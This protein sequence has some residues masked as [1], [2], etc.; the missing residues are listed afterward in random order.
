MRRS[1][2]AEV[3]TEVK[4]DT[5]SEPDNLDI[6]SKGVS[7]DEN[8]TDGVND[9]N[10][11]VASPSSN[12]RTVTLSE[13]S[14]V[15]GQAN[16]EAEASW[17]QGV[18]ET[19]SVSPRSPESSDVS[20]YITSTTGGIYYVHDEMSQPVT[21]SVQKEDTVNL[22]VSEGLPAVP[23]DATSEPA[24]VEHTTHSSPKGDIVDDHHNIIEVTGV[25]RYETTTNLPGESSYDDHTTSEVTGVA[26][27]ESET[28]FSAANETWGSST[29][30]EALENTDGGDDSLKTSGQAS[31]LSLVPTSDT[32]L[33]TIEQTSP[34]D[35]TAESTTTDGSEDNDDEASEAVSYSEKAPW[36]ERFPARDGCLKY[37]SLNTE[38]EGFDVEV[39]PR[40]DFCISQAE[41]CS[42]TCSPILP[43]L[44]PPMGGRSYRSKAFFTRP[45]WIRDVDEYFLCVIS[46]QER[47]CVATVALNRQRGST[48]QP[49]SA[50]E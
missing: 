2:D 19:S 39:D 29:L 22:V 43:R 24:S 7:H 6:T 31:D 45:T 20:E 38:E 40:E 41:S 10:T 8:T 42:G 28:T 18:S 49:L 3:E 34:R 13:E 17:R 5:E 32:I 14:Y 35:N 26:N 48:A 1:F 30:T 11:L 4:V 50:M 27:M 33:A 44:D 47:L 9:S 25:V 46:G 37:I 21:S 36:R 16:S 12:D 23:H 15:T